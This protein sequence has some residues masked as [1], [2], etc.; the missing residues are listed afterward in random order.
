MFTEHLPLPELPPN[1]KFLYQN[2]KGLMLN[3][4]REQN[5][6]AWLTDRERFLLRRAT[7][8]QVTVVACEQ[9]FGETMEEAPEYA[10]ELSI[11]LDGVEDTTTGKIISHEA[12][13]MPQARIERHTDITANEELTKM[14]L[15][16]LPPQY[17][18]VIAAVVTRHAVRNVQRMVEES[19]RA[20]DLDDP[21][22]YLAM[23]HE[24][25]MRFYETMS[26]NGSAKTR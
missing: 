19:E 12:F 5:I 14:L 24:A 6:F 3:G 20:R 25:L 13:R 17:R 10:C 1:A 2:G 16:Q 15:M 26:R 18:K 8:S 4:F 9:D 22:A 21:D 23:R 7:G 11:D